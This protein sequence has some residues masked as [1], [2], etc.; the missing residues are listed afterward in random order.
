MGE[1]NNLISRLVWVWAR[2]E[3]NQAKRLE[4]LPVWTEW[5]RDRMEWRNTA[6]LLTFNR[7]IKLSI[8][9]LVLFFKKREW[10][11][12]WQVRYYQ[13]YL[14]SVSRPELIQPKPNMHCQLGLWQWQCRTNGS[15]R[16]S[17]WSE[18]YSWGLRS[19]WICLLSCWD[20]PRTHYFFLKSLLWNGNLKSM[21]HHCIS[22]FL[23]FFNI[24]LFI[25]IG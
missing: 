4:I 13:H 1:S 8:C 6:R 25:L 16:Q 7:K 14:V 9:A 22:F 20:L 2:I 12:R 17:I 15:G 10:P 24:N 5:Y 11:Q 21:S 23:L 19:H 18:D 3:P